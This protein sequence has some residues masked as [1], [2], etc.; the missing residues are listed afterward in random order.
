MITYHQQRS[1][2]ATRRQGTVGGAYD[3]RG[4]AVVHCGDVITSTPPSHPP[5]PLHPARTERIFCFSHCLG[6]FIDFDTALKPPPGTTLL[7][8]SRALDFKRAHQ[9]TPVRMSWSDPVFSSLLC[10]CYV[11]FWVLCNFPACLWSP[12]F[13][14]CAWDLARLCPL[15]YSYVKSM[16]WTLGITIGKNK[17]SYQYLITQFSKTII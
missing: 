14:S 17:V 6:F 1:I 7:S 12:S 13:E 11:T 15:F 16:L 3:S 10:R 5:L 9:K 8:T 2:S 4:G